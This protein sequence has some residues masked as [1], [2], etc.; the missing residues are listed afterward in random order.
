MGNAES[1][2]FLLRVWKHDRR[3][4][5]DTMK[6]EEVTEFQIQIEHI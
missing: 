6:Q 4:D 2:F 3:I 1:I 5:Y